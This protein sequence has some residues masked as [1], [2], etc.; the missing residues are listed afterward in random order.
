VGRGDTLY[1]LARRYY[2]DAKRYRDIA[3]ANGLDPSVT[4]S[5]GTDLV[6]P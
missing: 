3:S 2:G 5:V 6:L 1:S 4:L